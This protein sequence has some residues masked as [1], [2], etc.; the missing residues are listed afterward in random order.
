MAVASAAC[1]E[2]AAL[3]S[4]AHPSP[5]GKSETVSPPATA[6]STLGHPD[7]RPTTV[8][9][10][11]TE[12]ARSSVPAALPTNPTRWSWPATVTGTPA[13]SPDHTDASADTR[14]I[15][16]PAAITGGNT[17]TSKPAARAT[18][19]NHSR[20]DMSKQPVRA[21]SDD[22]VASAPV[23]ARNTSSGTPS[24][25]IDSPPA[26]TL[27]QCSISHPSLATVAT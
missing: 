25:R 26:D 8:S 16:S 15:T 21:A 12:L 20:R 2:R 19:G 24:H 17:S 27:G 6:A 3:V 9:A 22:S 23:S 10:V 7:D 5:P 4:T 11:P 18:S 13:G 14:P 1:P